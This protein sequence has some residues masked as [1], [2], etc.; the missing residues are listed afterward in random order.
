MSTRSLA[1]SILIAGSAACVGNIGDGGPD[2]RTNDPGVESESGPRVADAR[3]RRLTPRE[4]R[5]SLHMLLDVAL[6]PTVIDG[7]AGRL[8]TLETAHAGGLAAMAAG[9]VMYSEADL[10]TAESVAADLSRAVFSDPG[11]REALVGCTP[12]AV[13]DDCA[14]AFVS[15]YARRVLRRP[16]TDDELYDLSQLAGDAAAQLNSPWAGLEFVVTALLQSP[17]FLYRVELGGETGDTYGNRPYTPFELASRVS[18]FLTGGPPDEALLDAAAAGRLDDDEGLAAEVDRLLST[19]AAA[20]SLRH[21]F[22]EW[23][24]LE[25]LPSLAKDETTYA[26]S[27]TLGRDLQQEAQLLF[28]RVVIEGGADFRALFTHPSTF[29]NT[30][31]AELYGMSEQY[32]EAG[33][34][35]DFVEVEIPADWHRGGLLTT[36]AFLAAHARETRTSPTLRGN[37]IRSLLLC[38]ETPA[39]PPDV[40]VELPEIDPDTPMTLR[41]L[42][43]SK[44]G[45]NPCA[46]CHDRMD[47]LGYAFEHFDTTGR[48]RLEDNGLPIDATGHLDGVNFD[49][50][51]ELAALLRDEPRV[52]GCLVRR[53]YRHGTGHRENTSERESLTPI[54][55][56]YLEQADLNEVRRQIVLSYGFRYAADLH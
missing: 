44:V 13:D 11:A 39:P 42:Q 38:E 41:E 14:Q 30:D 50:A 36:G 48:H 54:S 32:A 55:D 29:I 34:D 27:P 22:S 35:G 47:P 45:Q 24:G 21:F 16:P 20:D 37:F 23:F 53:F 8:G 1:L 31:L 12:S 17:H 6:D 33:G 26:W 40:D 3:L 10:A 46:T 7:A 28:D 56:G 43:T 9:E 49:G 52:V 51:K 25:H 4:Y 5:T 18:F 2:H 15:R 19:P